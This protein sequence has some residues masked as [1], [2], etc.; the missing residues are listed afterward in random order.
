MGKKRNRIR[1]EDIVVAAED[2]RIPTKNRNP[3]LYYYEMRHDDLDWTVPIE[4]RKNVLVNF[5][6]TLV[7]KAPLELVGGCLI[8]TRKEKRVVCEKMQEYTDKAVESS[9]YPCY[10]Y[11]VSP[12]GY[13]VKN[14]I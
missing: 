4:I 13:Y 14:P 3:E 10:Y 6:G 2:A 7:T 8:P 9:Q 11:L 5:L 1:L 12:E